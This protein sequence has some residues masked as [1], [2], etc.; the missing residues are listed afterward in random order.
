MFPKFNRSV[1]DLYSKQL[2]DLNIMTAEEQNN[3]A[4]TFMNYLNTELENLDKYQPDE[5]YFQRQWEG[6]KSAT[7]EITTWDTGLEYSLLNFIGR[8]SVYYP[9]DFVC[10]SYAD[11]FNPL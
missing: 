6:I 4:E 10:V 2:I 3:V 9:K 8:S 5:S 1:P 11:S 7:N